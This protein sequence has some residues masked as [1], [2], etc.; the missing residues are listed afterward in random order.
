MCRNDPRA[1]CGSCRWYA[2]SG[3]PKKRSYE[4][5]LYDGQCRGGLPI[6]WQHVFGSDWCSHHEYAMTPSPE[7]TP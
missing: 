4:G 3:K 7:V 6:D 1:T 2:E 5:P